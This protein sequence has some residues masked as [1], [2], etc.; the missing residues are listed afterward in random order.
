M[1]FCVI[2]FLGYWKCLRTKTGAWRRDLETQSLDHAET[3]L[4][5]FQ[6]KSVERGR[7]KISGRN[8]N[9]YILL[10]KERPRE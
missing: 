8:P 6:S 1:T 10:A 5:L 7:R 4:A 2:R 9:F 3:S